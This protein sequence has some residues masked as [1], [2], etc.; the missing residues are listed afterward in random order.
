MKRRSAWMGVACAC[1]L[2]GGIAL[3]QKGTALVHGKLSSEQ[4]AAK[5]ARWSKIPLDVPF[6]D[7][8]KM[9]E[10]SAAAA[11][12]A[13]GGGGGGAAVAWS[14]LISAP[15]IEREIGLI[16][17]AA[18]E[19]VK[20]PGFYKS[21]GWAEAEK[22]HGMLAALFQVSANYD[23]KVKWQDKATGMRDV[24]APAGIGAMNKD[25]AGFEAAKKSTDAVAALLKNGKVD[26][27][28]GD[29]MKP[30]G[31]EVVEFVT[32]MKRMEDAQRLKLDKWTTTEN[33]FTAKAEVIIYEAELMAMMSQ[34]ILDESYSLASEGD[35]RDLATEL[36][37]LGVAIAQGT[38]D[39]QF[40]KVRSAVG[41]INKACDNCHTKYR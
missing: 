41:S 5:K 38:K 15:T 17:A 7:V 36:R 13:K 18:P 11:A 31:G 9:M 35:Y 12:A 22:H 25:D 20:N 30:W 10:E 37:D 3:A 28:A 16:A 29:K 39:K 21:K 1:F 6:P 32:I 40:D 26:A 34:I 14:K 19:D 8:K 33:E 27:P 4:V 23:G 24:A 2:A